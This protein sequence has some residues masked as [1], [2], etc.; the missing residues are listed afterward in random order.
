MD[1]IARYLPGI[2]LAYT[3]FL[4][5]ILSPG[6]NVMAVIGTSMSL[7]KKPG[8][9]VALGVG[10]GSCLWA[11]LTVAGLTT[12][13]AAHP[14]ALVAI[15][16]AGGAYL[17]FLS[18]RA[19]RAAAS[20]QDLEAKSLNGSQRALTAYF[21]RGLAIN[22]TNPKA[23]LAWVAIVS[24]GLQENAPL[25]VGIAITVGTSVLSVVFHCLYALAFSTA[26]MV[27]FYSRARRWIQA[28]LGGFFAFAGV[29]LLVGRM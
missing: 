25:W 26:P 13:I 15:K 2:A 29:K 6:P 23:L 24:L 21:W 19:F 18:Y 10:T 14:G 8:T 11:G 12:L 22:M 5:G 20:V 9:A 4:L 28:A 1:E 16:I 3:A 17:L 7:G 27:R